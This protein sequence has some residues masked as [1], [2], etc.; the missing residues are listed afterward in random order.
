MLLDNISMTITDS[1]LAQ[2][3]LTL[4]LTL[5]LPFLISLPIVST[6]AGVVVDNDVY[7]VEDGKEPTVMQRVVV[8]CQVWLTTTSNICSVLLMV[9]VC[10]VS[11]DAVF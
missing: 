9:I 2:R 4:T 10:E 11:V 7:H 1:I 3:L 6:T 5:T 8:Q